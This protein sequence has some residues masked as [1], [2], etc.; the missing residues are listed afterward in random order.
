MEKRKFQKR[1]DLLNEARNKVAAMQKRNVF[2][3][4]VSA[5]NI[6]IKL[7]EE[8]QEMLSENLKMHERLKLANLLSGKKKK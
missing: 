7:S 1:L 6:L 8:F 2:T 5:M 3:L 4:D